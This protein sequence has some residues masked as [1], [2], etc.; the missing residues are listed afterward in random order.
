LIGTWAGVNGDHTIYFNACMT[1]KIPEAKLLLEGPGA[2]R[3]F[4]LWRVAQKQ[5]RIGSD[6][7]G[8]GGYKVG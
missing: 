7:E 5:K 3:C 8:A 6:N 2:A 4:Y 1:G